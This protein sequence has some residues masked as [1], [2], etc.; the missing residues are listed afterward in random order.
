MLESSLDYGIMEIEYDKLYN[1]L[2][3]LLKR[4]ANLF[5]NYS[6]IISDYLGLINQK[7]QSELKFAHEKIVRFH[8]EQSKKLAEIE[9]EFRKG[10]FE[11]ILREWIINTNNGTNQYAS[12]PLQFSGQ[13]NK[14]EIEILPR[15]TED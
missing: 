15:N 8:E 11:S 7:N 2:I 12:L 5:V 13:T 4:N 10:P 14:L 3:F 1:E 9:N 6:F